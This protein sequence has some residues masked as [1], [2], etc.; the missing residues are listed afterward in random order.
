MFKRKNSL[1]EE[2][3]FREEIVEVVPGQ[4]GIGSIYISNM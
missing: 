2:T 4:H 3:G 1:A